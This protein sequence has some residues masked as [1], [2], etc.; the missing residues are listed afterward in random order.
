MLG[1]PGGQIGFANHGTGP[2]GMGWAAHQSWLG[3]SRNSLGLW[4]RVLAQVEAGLGPAGDDNFVN[5]IAIP[6]A[7]PVSQAAVV[8]SWSAGWVY[9]HEN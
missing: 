8:D 6:I 7:L 1:Y 4:W 9:G 2:V 5:G 3:W